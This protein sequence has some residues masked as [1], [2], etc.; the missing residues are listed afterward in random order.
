MFSVLQK[1]I[2]TLVPISAL[3]NQAGDRGT[4][5]VAKQ[6][7]RWL[8]ATGQSAWQILP[9]HQTHL[10][11]G[12]KDIH[13]PSPYKSYGVGLDPKLSESEL[14]NLDISDY[15]KFIKQ[16]EFWLADYALF[17]AIRDELETDDW[18]SWPTDIKTRIP[19]AIESW[20]SRLDD[21][22]EAHS[23]EQYYLHREFDQF[24]HLA[25]QHRI[26]LIGDLPFYLPIQSPLVWANQK[27]FNLSPAG[28][29]LTVSGV[30]ETPSS[31][32]G[33]Q[34][35]GH[36]IYLW[37][38]FEARIVAMRLF[39]LR[40][41]YLSGLFD[42]IRLDHARGL[43]LYGA[44]DPI[45]QSQDKFI[46]GP[47]SLALEELIHFAR[48]QNSKVFVEDTG[49]GLAEFR[50]MINKLEVPGIRI[51]RYALDE[52]H[53]RVISIYAD[54]E[55]YPVNSVAYTS[56]HD[57]ETLLGYLKLLSIEQ[58]QLL[59][60]YTRADYNPD[61]KIFAVNL[62][63]RIIT[64]PSSVVIIPIQDWLLMTHR[65][66]LP[67]TEQEISDQ[68]WKYQVEFPVENL[69]AN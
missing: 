31:H 8:N 28:E 68:N 1:Q 69:P 24:H 40:I 33:R 66:N 45:D 26:E 27:A 14:S 21:K 48:R 10:E 17:C 23:R 59:S 54:I 43:F 29:M 62:R 51:F 60:Q 12:S 13:I 57:T 39:K 3:W 7:L 35:W 9:L 16:N 53:N 38:D 22:V 42:N 32:H 44:L 47:G 18:R 64:S 34:L 67:G 65:I 20:K 55:K 63:E 58:K 36:P 19:E 25:S 61:D 30:P 52:K 6:F 4:F 41:K 2:G 56:T 50:E 46:P 49:E 11:I 37:H 15:D 5:N